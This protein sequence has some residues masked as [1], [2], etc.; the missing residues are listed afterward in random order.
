MQEFCQPETVEQRQQ[1]LPAA[2]MAGAASKH[3]DP[4]AEMTNQQYLNEEGWA[5]S[6][7]PHH[8][9][10]WVVSA[11]QDFHLKQKKWE[12]RLCTV[13]HEVWPTRTCLHVDPM[14]YVCTRCKHDN[15]ETKRYSEEN[16]ML[17]GRVPTCLQ[18]LSQV[19]EM[20]I[21]RACP[22]MC[23][24]RKHGGQRGYKGHV[25]NLPQDIQGFLDRLPCNVKELPVLLLRRN[26]EDNTHTDL[27]VRRDR[28]FTALQWLQ[29]N[30]P[31]YS[32]ITIDHTALQQL[33]HDGVP[34]DL[35]ATDEGEEQQD[36][37]DDSG[38][39]DADTYSSHSFL[40]LPNRTATEDEAIRAVVS[41]SDPLEWPNIA[42]QPINEFRTAGLAT[43]A[44]PTLFP[45]GTGDPTCP[46]RQ[47]PVTF[48]EAFKHLIRY[49][50]NM[51]G[52]F[53]WRFA[54]HPR[55]PYWALNIKLRHQLIS[56]TTVY[57]HQH[58]SDAHLTV[59]DLR[60]MVGH[61]SAEQLMSRLQRY[62]AKVQG[63]SQ[64]WYQRYNELRTLIEHK[65][66][67]TFF[68]TVSSANSYWPELHNLLPHS[69]VSEPSHSMR[70]HAV[71]DNPHITDWFFT[72]K[73]SDWV[74]H[75]LYDALGAEWHWYRIEYQ[76]RGSTHA[77]GCAKLHNDPGICQLVEKAAAAWAISEE[78]VNSKDA[79]MKGK[80]P[81]LQCSSTLTGL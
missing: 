38:D 67:P 50:D 58:P 47:R 48:T 74:Q 44:F 21:A 24:Y 15:N 19:E 56:Q 28:V 22:I 12:H 13:C 49:A 31:F 66:P 17:P 3:S 16:D 33:P 55:F 26:G 9:Q 45:Y 71:I 59:E 29:S 27:C 75:W 42:E 25:L 20:L 65:G 61:L 8:R 6:H 35:L 34:P 36:A 43:Q 2:H 81:R 41:G 51:D 10:P 14:L 64:Y 37:L 79:N 18:G 70:V 73:L 77:H 76:A 5:T 1:S 63:S 53:L 32:S 11:M 46:G 23:V 78:Q 54:S 4:T 30:N 80:K 57:L 52:T 69:Q 72:S 60:D 62:A 39:V 68:W 7:L 40:P